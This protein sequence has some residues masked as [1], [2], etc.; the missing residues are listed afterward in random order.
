M[1]REA[2]S[3]KCAD[4]NLEVPALMGVS[5][6]CSIIAPLKRH[7][8]HDLS[9]LLLL[10]RPFW[11]TSSLC[12]KTTPTGALYLPRVVAPRQ[13]WHG[14]PA[15]RAPQR[16]PLAEGAVLKKKFDD[17]FAATKYT[18]ALETIRKL[19]TD[20]AQGIRVRHD[21]FMAPAPR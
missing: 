2:L 13:A 21:I 3:K 4:I 5:K 11:R 10:C 20:Q 8:A 12:I 1:Q 15:H 16:R 6:V 19:K 14:R 7:A 9:C 17:I 18:K